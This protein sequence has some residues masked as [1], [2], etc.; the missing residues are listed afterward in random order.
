M[1]DRGVPINPLLPFRNIFTSPKKALQL[2]LIL[3]M[4]SLKMMTNQNCLKKFPQPIVL[5][6][7]AKIQNSLQNEN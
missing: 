3:L 7:I 5:Q 4:K 2:L 6:E 1:L